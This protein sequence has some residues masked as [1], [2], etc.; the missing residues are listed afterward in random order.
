MRDIEGVASYHGSGGV[1]E[2]P[3]SNHSALELIQRAFEQATRAKGNKQT[4]MTLAVLNNRLL[5]LTD[6][7][8]K[9][10]NFGATDLRALI[11]G[12]APVVQLDHSDGHTKVFWNADLA[13]QSA[14]S[15]M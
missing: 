5:A 1:M 7:T 9:P 11:G 2:V 15:R 10:T 6:R 14:S 12:L 8:F 4:S 3:K 13:P